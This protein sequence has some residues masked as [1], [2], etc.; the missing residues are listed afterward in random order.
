MKHPTWCVR[1]SVL[2]LGYCCTL[3]AQDGA[4]LYKKHCAVCHDQTSPR[5]PPRSALQKMSAVRILRTLDFGLM[6][7]VAYPLRR[8]ERQAI[9]SFLGAGIEELPFPQSAF[10][11]DKQLPISTKRS[12]GWMGWSPTFSNARFQGTEAAHLTASQ[13]PSLKFKWAFG[14]PGDITAFG[15]PAV[16]GDV[17]FVGSASGTVQA[18][19]ARTGCLYWTFQANGPVRAAPLVI[20]S[21]GQYSILFGDQV[22]WF[23]AV[24]AINGKLIWKNRIDEHESSRL[25]GSAAFNEGT[26]FVPAS[27]WEETRTISPDYTCCTFRGS[28][29]ALRASDGSRLWKTYLVEPPR[30]TGGSKRGTANFGPSGAPVWSAPTVD[31][32]RH[33]LYITTGDNYSSPATVTSDAVIALSMKTGQIVWS[34]QVTSGDI[35]NVGCA[36]G[37]PNCPKRL[38]PD[39]DFGS[40]AILVSGQRR[41]LLI[42]GQ[43]SGTVYALDPEQNG[44][45][46]WQVQV[47]KGGSHG[48]IMWGMASD[49]TNVYAAVADEVRKLGNGSNTSV[50]NADFDPNLG[51]GL[52][53]LRLVD[54]S[55]VWFAPGHPCDPPRPGCTPAQPAALTS[56][57]GAV[58]SGSMD[59]HIRAFSTEDGHL[60]WEFDTARDYSTVDGIPA[61]GGSLD[62]AGPVIV[63]GML[64]VNSGYPRFGGMP[65]NVLL[66]F[67]VDGK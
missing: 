61:H 64:Y 20:P 37:G 22:G 15:A 44:R 54:G 41:D 10:C 66:A 4:T 24:D 38:G 25:T 48:G 16:H 7:N 36:V 6:M 35:F 49:G 21:S 59:G 30:K 40:S 60:L 8:G 39:F 43:K 33:L 50:G 67:S 1:G 19:N 47:G 45:I 32:K 34:K 46:L 63:D 56:I 57:S 29:T 12:G 2:L 53:A 13:V 14:F 62:G 26:V 31:A 11:G 58:F 3:L 23:Y 17:L 55:K 52:T 27:S 9:A 51:G 18:M 28:V 42:A 65:G 5:I